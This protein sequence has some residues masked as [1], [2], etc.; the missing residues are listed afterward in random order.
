[1]G[2]PHNIIDIGKPFAHIFNLA[3]LGMV[4]VGLS[5][6]LLTTRCCVSKSLIVIFT[7]RAQIFFCFGELNF[8]IAQ[9]VFQFSVFKLSQP[10]HLL[11]LVFCAF[12]AVNT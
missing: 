6:D 2:F 5:R 11:I 9:G 4:D 7:S 8:N 10:Q 12:L 1:M 3:N